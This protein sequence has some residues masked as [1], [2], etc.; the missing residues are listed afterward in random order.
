MFRI[1]AMDWPAEE[2]EIRRALEPIAGVRGLA[3][4][5]NVLMVHVRSMGMGVGRR[6]MGVLVTVAALWHHFVHM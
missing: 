2:S 1:E 3:G 4:S 5:V 6:F